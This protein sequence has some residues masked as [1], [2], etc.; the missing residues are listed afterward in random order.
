MTM[1]R[2][3]V[4]DSVP[5]HME[6]LNL[7]AF[8]KGFE[9]GSQTLNRLAESGE[10]DGLC[11]GGRSSA[12]EPSVGQAPWFVSPLRMPPAAVWGRGFCPAAALPGGVAAGHEA[13]MFVRR[14][15]LPADHRRLNRYAQDNENFVLVV[16][17]QAALR[18]TASM[19]LFRS[20]ATRW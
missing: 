20:S 10:T 12:A 2:T 1:F 3:T 9:Y 13:W 8:D 15:P 7:K 19:S 6:K 4:G 14:V 17:Y 18:P 5:P 11:H 16:G